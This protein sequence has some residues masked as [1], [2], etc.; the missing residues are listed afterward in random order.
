MP[1]TTSVIILA[2]TNQSSP[3]ST[4][5]TQYCNI[6]KH[7]LKLITF[8]TQC[9]VCFESCHGEVLLLCEH[10]VCRECLIRYFSTTTC[11]FFDIAMFTFSNLCKGMCIIR[12]EMEVLFG[13]YVSSSSFQSMLCRHLELHITEG[14]GNQIRCPEVDCYQFIPNVGEAFISA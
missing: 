4:V 8:Y 5:L 1:F 11:F 10:Q 13:F 12:I 6:H 14:G 9:I 7:D 3:L 2:S